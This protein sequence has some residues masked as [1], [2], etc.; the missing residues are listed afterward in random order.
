MGI[1]FLTTLVVYKPQSHKS[2]FVV[3]PMQKIVSIVCI[4]RLIPYC[5][6][7]LHQ[8]LENEIEKDWQKP[9]SNYYCL[10][11]LLPWGGNQFLEETKAAR[12][13]RQHKTNNSEAETHHPSA[14]YPNHL[15][16]MAALQTLN[17]CLRLFAATCTSAAT[18]GSC[19]AEAAVGQDHPS[20]LLEL[21]IR[22]RSEDLRSAGHHSSIIECPHW[23]SM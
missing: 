2:R 18:L 8:R 11:P 9:Q 22:E 7:S 17:R 5:W 19:C 23:K 21:R 13:G 6:T 12:P 20:E 14:W 4:S 3:Q 15:L 10:D 16:V 1:T